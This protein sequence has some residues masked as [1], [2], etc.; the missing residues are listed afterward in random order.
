MT[1]QL[2][3]RELGMKIA[4]WI[5]PITGRGYHVQAGVAVGY[6]FISLSAALVIVVFRRSMKAGKQSYRIQ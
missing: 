3:R 6:E 2:A 4:V 5:L 1:W